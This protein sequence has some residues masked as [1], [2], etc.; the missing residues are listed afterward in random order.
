MNN[1]YPEED[2]LEQCIVDFCEREKYR[3]VRMALQFAKKA[4]EGQY[5]KTLICSDEKIPYITHP[6]FICN[7]A[8]AIGIR[9]ETVLTSL[10]LHDVCED[11][12]YT[13]EELPFNDE[14]RETVR[15]VTKKKNYRA[16]TYYGAIAENRLAVI[17]KSLDRLHNISEMA[18]AFPKDK[19]IRYINETEKYYY[20]MLEKIKNDEEYKTQVLLIEYHLK[21]MIKTQKALLGTETAT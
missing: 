2:R 21:S 4:H 5:R 14:I 8:Y 15:L 12:G 16:K 1:Y 11:C 3:N 19:M 9:N 10:L 6:V 7:Y 13:A 17:V 18:T 20:P